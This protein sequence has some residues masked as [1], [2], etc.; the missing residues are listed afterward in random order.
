MFCFGGLLHR[1]SREVVLLPLLPLSGSSCFA[2]VFNPCRVSRLYRNVAQWH[3]A[4]L[5]SARPWVPFLV[6]KKSK[7]GKDQKKKSPLKKKKKDKL[8]L[9]ALTVLPPRLLP[10]AAGRCRTLPDAAGCC[11]TLPDTARHCQ[12]LLGAREAPGSALGASVCSCLQPSRTTV[13]NRFIPTHQRGHL[14]PQ[15]QVTQLAKARG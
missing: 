11:R 7:V 5:A 3:G 13:R 1:S 14:G 6:P 9:P 10:D 2:T 8:A 4:R 15:S 12:T